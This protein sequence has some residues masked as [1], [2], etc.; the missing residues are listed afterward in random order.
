MSEPVRVLHV[1]GK[2]NMGGAESRIMDLYRNIDRTLVQ[3]DFVVHYEDRGFFED[4]IEALGGR[5]FR[6]PRFKLYNV[7]SYKQAWMNF[8][9]THQ[10]EFKV[11][12]GHIT[13]SASVYLPIAKRSGVPITVAHARS[14][15]VDA[16]IKGL[17][18]RLMRR[19]LYKRADRLLACSKAAG[20]SVFGQK[21]WDRGLVRFVPN[22]IDV[23]KFAFDQNV[24]NQKRAEL[25]LEDNFVIG[26]VGRF[27]Y[28]KNH[29]FLLRVFRDFVEDWYAE[30]EEAG[31]TK[32]PVLIL[33]GEGKRLP[34]MKALAIE[35]GISG[36]VI[37]LGNQQDINSYYQAMDYFLY[38]SRYEGLPGTV[39]EAQACGLPV[40]MSD[41][42]CE[43]VRATDLI[44]VMSL[45]QSS[46]SWA[47]Q[48]VDYVAEK[49]RVNRF[50]YNRLIIDAGFD[51]KKQADEMM[52][53]YLC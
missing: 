13:S 12:Q 46:D 39:V 19:K 32:K 26:H 23:R 31:L 38:P 2:L 47:R 6:V 5:V 3:F 11:V 30:R 15:G 14:A 16:G 20:I 34:E 8:F 35:L 36:S 52:E 44:S 7:F 41:T 28:S 40:L 27:H 9:M 53:F 48:I 43:E 1:F 25:D 21:A 17:L 45:K 42:I 50:E 24:R 33:L 22:A 4:E 10:G 37:F 51:V 49:K 18:T 29:E